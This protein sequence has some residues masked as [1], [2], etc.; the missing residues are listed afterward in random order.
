LS[1]FKQ[2]DVRAVDPARII[3]GAAVGGFSTSD[4]SKV[5][6]A[7]S[8]VINNIANATSARVDDGAV[9]EIAD[10]VVVRAGGADDDD[11]DA[12][13]GMGGISSVFDFTAEKLVD[14]SRDLADGDNVDEQLDEDAPALDLEA[15]T[16]GK[17]AGAAIIGVAGTLQAGKSDVSAGAA[18]TYNGV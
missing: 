13:L 1:G 5:S 4:Q 10:N 2:L 7:G 16:T 8:F 15:P 12:A 6:L 17:D 11:L 9:I 14:P 3:A 18:L